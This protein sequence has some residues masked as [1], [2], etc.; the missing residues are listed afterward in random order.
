MSSTND[1]SSTAQD[2]SSTQLSSNNE[3]SSMEQD[4]QPE[5]P[6]PWQ[7][8]KR[9]RTNTDENLDL[10]QQESVGIQ[11]KNRYAVFA[12]IDQNENTSSGKERILK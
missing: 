5:S 4:V 11:Q 10:S 3:N 1:P 12:N 6:V 7:R 9:R 2:S 8:V